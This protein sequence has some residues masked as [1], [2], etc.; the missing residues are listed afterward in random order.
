[1]SKA[2][3]VMT[4]RQCRAIEKWKAAMP[5]PRLHLPKR[6]VEKWQQSEFFTDLPF[7]RRPITFF[8]SDLSTLWR[9]KNKRPS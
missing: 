9:G 2:N 5:L 7:E 8:H 3:V 6:P 1:M 4:L